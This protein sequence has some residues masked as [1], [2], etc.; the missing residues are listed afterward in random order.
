M[1]RLWMLALIA[2]L[3]VCLAGARVHAADND[4]SSDGSDG[5]V[6]TTD[7]GADGDAV[8][9]PDAVSSAD[10]PPGVAAEPSSRAGSQDL[11]TMNFQ[12]VDIPVLAKFISEI[13]G[14]NFVLA[15]SVRGKI[16]II[17]PTK[18]T[19]YQAYSIFQSVL[20]IK[21]FTTVTAGSIIKI[22]P[23]RDVRQ[24]AELTTSQ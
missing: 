23:A 22:V 5:T 4:D 2:A 17:S 18:V 13:T 14:K 7:G 8:A 10:S 3:L 20:Q 24:S 19:P 1:N 12:N 11:I 6:A 21:G 9:G 15:E 16:S